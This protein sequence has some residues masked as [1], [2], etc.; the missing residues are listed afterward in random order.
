MA[1]LYLT[2]RICL[3]PVTP[4]VP[5]FYAPGR[6]AGIQ[7]GACACAISTIVIQAAVS[8]L[9]LQYYNATANKLYRYLFGR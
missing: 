3:I 6:P 4:V 1:V 9:N 5:G 8:N 2:L 7:W